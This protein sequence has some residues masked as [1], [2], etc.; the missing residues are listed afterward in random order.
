MEVSTEVFDKMAQI[1]APSSG[2]QPPSQPGGKEAIEQWFEYT[3]E[4]LK[5][6]SLERET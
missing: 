1:Y 2:N 4:R 3:H 6:K 5:L